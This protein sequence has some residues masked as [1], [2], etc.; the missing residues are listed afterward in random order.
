MLFIDTSFFLLINPTY[1]ILS[2]SKRTMVKV[3]GACHPAASSDDK[4]T[5]FL[6]FKDMKEKIDKINGTPILFDHDPNKPIGKILGAKIDE[7]NRLV[8][9]FDIAMDTMNG[10]E[11]LRLLR[12]KKICNLSMGMNHLIAEGYDWMSVVGKEI[13]EVS[14]T[15]DPD[16]PDTDIQSIGENGERHDIFKHFLQKKREYHELKRK[17]EDINDPSLPVKLQKV[18][19]EAVDEFKNALIQS[20]TQKTGENS[21]KDE[22]KIVDTTNSSVD[23]NKE[24]KKQTEV[25]NE[26]KLDK[27]SIG[28][29]EPNKVQP[30]VNQTQSVPTID[31]K[32]VVKDSENKNNDIKNDSQKIQTTDVPKDNAN[33]SLV[34][35]KNDKP[36]KSNEP[37]ITPIVEPL[38][39]IQSNVDSKK[40]SDNDKDGSKVDQNITDEKK[41]SI[42]DQQKLDVSNLKP[43]T[44]IHFPN[45]TEKTSLVATAANSKGI[46]LYTFLKTLLLSFLPI[47]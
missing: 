35:E 6:R 18:E 39:P 43:T 9:E 5:L 11:A 41:K 24:E 1:K 28:I 37:T 32:P 8:I 46:L 38:K 47:Y 20:K 7:K 22:K 14:I 21:A 17:L 13:R 23:P 10:I 36:Q 4:E 27:S 15:D 31:N 33:S 29:P 45:N 19:N 40:V 42:S 30:E 25:P 12:D 3:I 26:D 44:Q 16:M 34:T 2:L